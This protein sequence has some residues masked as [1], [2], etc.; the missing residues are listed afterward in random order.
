M[1]AGPNT[2]QLF[3]H[4]HMIFIT[5][6]RQFPL[7]ALHPHRFHIRRFLGGYPLE[8]KQAFEID[9]A[10]VFFIAD[11]LIHKRLGEARLV[12]FVMAKATITVR[13]DDHILVKSRAKLQSESDRVSDR[14]RFIAVDMENRHLQHFHHVGC[15]GRRPRRARRRGEADLIVDDDVNH[16]A[17]FI[18]IE[19]L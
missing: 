10:D 11:R 2:L 18:R 4:R 1:V 6:R 14:F 9:L 5:R 15:V 13:V 8:R 12:A 17:N 7:E 16:A 19:P 3:A